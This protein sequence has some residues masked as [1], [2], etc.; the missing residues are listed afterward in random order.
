MGASAEHAK[1]AAATG[2]GDPEGAAADDVDAML[3][4]AGIQP[5]GAEPL[6]QEVRQL[7]GQLVEFQRGDGGARGGGGF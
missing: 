4:R 5:A 1:L 6:V 7:L 2:G 3:Q